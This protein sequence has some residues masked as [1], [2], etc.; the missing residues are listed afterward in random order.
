LLLRNGEEIERE[1]SGCRANN[2]TS[3]TEPRPNRRISEK[4]CLGHSPVSG[5]FDA[6][7]DALF[8]QTLTLVDA[9]GLLAVTRGFFELALDSLFSLVAAFVTFP[10][11][12]R[13]L[14]REIKFS[15]DPDFFGF[16]GSVAPV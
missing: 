10:S 15:L 11:D 14:V 7:G 5:Y 1:I 6:T 9:D 2:K 16:S 12:A 4:K 3:H 13:S 8:G